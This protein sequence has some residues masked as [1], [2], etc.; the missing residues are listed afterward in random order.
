MIAGRIGKA[1]RELFYDACRQTVGFS[2]FALTGVRHFNVP[3]VEEMRRGV[4]IVSNHQ[5]YLDPILV[6]MALPMRINYLARESLFR[7]APFGLLLRAVGTHPYGRD[8]V[9]RTG[10][11]KAMRILRAGEPLLVF[12]E[13]TRTRDGG[14][15]R[16]Q[17]GMGTLA[18]RCGVP[19]LPVCIAGAYE[20]WPRQRLLPGPRRVAVAF[21]NFIPSAGREPSEVVRAA[22]C[23]IERLM[24]Y[25]TGYLKGWHGAT[26]DR[27]RE[28]RDGG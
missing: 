8:R 12:P 15:G 23:D 2:V 21:G 14:L 26:R 17:R 7:L 18:I 4:L 19:V 20:S 16:F 25:L 6:G 22:V 27:C 28:G 9:D 10:L 1:G 3:P 11:K 24:R 13:G 5:S